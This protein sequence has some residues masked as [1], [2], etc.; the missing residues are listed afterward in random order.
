MG[1]YKVC[2]YAIAKNEAQ[3]VDRW[4]DSVGE[5]DRVIVLDTGSTDNTVE[6]LRAR[7]AEVT[8]EEIAPWRFD[9]A[10]N[11]SLELVPGDTDICVCVDLDEVFHPGWREALEAV[12]MPGTTQAEYRYTWNFN[13]DGSE[14]VV[15]W[16]EKIHSR[17]GWLWKHPVHETL[18]WVGEG[19]G[20][21]AVAAPGIQLDHRAD[22]TKSRA[23]YLPLLELSV[24]EDPDDDRNA[25]YLGREYMFRERW[26]DC[27]STLTRHLAMPNATWPDERAASM[28]FIARSYLHLNNADTARDW[29]L[30]AIAEAPYLREGY[31]ELAHMLYDL[32]E[33]EGVLY[34][35]GCAL[36]ITERPATYICEAAP[37]GSLPH[38]LRAIAFDR[39]GRPAEGLKEARRALEMEPDNERLQ[40]NV[41]YF[42]LATGG[43]V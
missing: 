3:F 5:A 21:K 6:L 41:A 16:Q 11:R 9:A 7:G 27:I 15:F 29:Y 26:G 12:W 39:T 37:W 36:R 17:H 22:P 18:E 2:V 20:T 34:F 1:R 25:H 28:R 14:G 23:S 30:R 10:R 35:T 43:S 40:Q 19:P 32:Q 4:M 33:W 38:D 31:V 24:Q 8:V 13:P 42:L